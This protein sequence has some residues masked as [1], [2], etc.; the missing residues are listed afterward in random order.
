M[1]L[2]QVALQQLIVVRL[3][4]K[5]NPRTSLKKRCMALCL[6]TAGKA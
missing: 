6:V 4:T 5:R 3:K 2:G 1:E